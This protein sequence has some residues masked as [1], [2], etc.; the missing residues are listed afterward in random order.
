MQ[1]ELCGLSLKKCN[2]TLDVHCIRFWM[3]AH[4]GMI[5]HIGST[6]YEPELQRIFKMQCSSTARICKI[7]VL[8]LNLQTC[9]PMKELPKLYNLLTLCARAQR[10]PAHYERLRESAEKL[11][12]WENIPRLAELHGIAPL[13]YTHLH[14]AKINIPASTENDLKAHYLRHNHANRVR[15]R[16][17]VEILQKFQSADVQVL[18]LKGMAIAHLVYP[19]PRLRPMSDI[20]LLV[21]KKDSQ[22]GQNLLLELGFRVLA[23]HDTPSDHHHLPVV[24]RRV[25]GVNIYIELHH[26]LTRALT[27]HTGFEALYPS[28]LSFEIKGISASTLSYENLLAHTYHHMIDAS[29]QPFRLIWLADMISLAERYTEQ[30]DWDMLP[31]K[32]YN[33]LKIINSLIPIEGVP[34]LDKGWLTASSTSSRKTTLSQGWPFSVIPSQSDAEHLQNAPKAFRPSDWWLRLY[35]G[36]PLNQ[37]LLGAK[38]RYPLHLFWG[39]WRVS[40]KGHITQRIKAYFTR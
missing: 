24:Q 1:R 37:L 6:P 10:N 33:A 8:F 23:S 4:S 30:I 20:D 34:K 22:R 31:P 28:A 5:L 27:P 29:I 14:A 39:I 17:L 32:I 13:V 11:P 26:N 35:F 9:S 19:H 7:R 2:R 16:A 3:R 15:T 40:G 38:I 12:S 25:D 36:L 21:S 18:V